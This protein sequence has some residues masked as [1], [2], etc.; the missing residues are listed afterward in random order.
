MTTTPA[1][2]GRIPYTLIDAGG[3]RKMRGGDA[4]VYLAIAAHT[5]R[6][7]LASIG[8]RRIAEV[9]GFYAGRVSDSMRRLIASGLIEVVDAGGGT[10]AAT[11]RLC[12]PSEPSANPSASVPSEPSATNAQR[13]GNGDLAL[14][15]LSSSAR[16]AP[17]RNRGTEEQSNAPSDEALRFPTEAGD[18]WTLP[19]DRLAEYRDTFPGI[20]IDRELR[21]ARLWLMDNPGKRKTPRGMPRFITGWLGRAKP[22]GQHH[23]G[24][25][26]PRA[27]L[28]AVCPLVEP[29]DED[30]QPCPTP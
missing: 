18:D 27:V 4:T 25:R 19:V 23:D 14:G 22:N 29:S 16:T 17:E 20:D 26:V 7:M 24:D 1:Q 28:D 21:K 12:V 13:S 30:F 8:Q 10:R 5:D 2:F 11:V 6:H 9:T 3:L 15:F